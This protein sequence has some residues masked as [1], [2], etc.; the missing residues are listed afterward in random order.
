MFMLNKEIYYNFS[1]NPAQW[2]FGLNSNTGELFKIN[3]FQLQ[4]ED[5]YMNVKTK[6]NK[7]H[8]LHI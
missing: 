7:K 4:V 2:H 3:I 1:K 8:T 6:Q 5:C